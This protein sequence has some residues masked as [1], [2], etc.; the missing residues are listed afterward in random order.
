MPIEAEHGGDES[1]GEGLAEEGEEHEDQGGEEGRGG[2]ELQ[3]PMAVERRARHR[4]EGERGPE[5]GL[6]PRVPR[7]GGV[8]E[9]VDA[10]VRDRREPQA[11]HIGEELEGLRELRTLRLRH[12]DSK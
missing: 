11:P 9:V 3:G 5:R 6:E 1:D 10:H 7:R 8:A 2:A 4:G 12:G